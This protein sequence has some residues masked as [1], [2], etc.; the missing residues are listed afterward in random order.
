[1]SAIRIGLHHFNLQ[2]QIDGFISKRSPIS[3]SMTITDRLQSL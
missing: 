2:Q 3:H 1:M